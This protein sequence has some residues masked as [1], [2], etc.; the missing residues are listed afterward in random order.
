MYCLT[1]LTL[2]AKTAKQFDAARRQGRLRTYDVPCGRCLAC[3]QHKRQEWVFRLKEE[4]KVSSSAYF[5]TLTYDED[6]LPR[7]DTGVPILRKKDVQ[8]F[9]HRLRKNVEVKKNK[10]NIRYYLVG[11]Y[12]S[13]T[14]RPH[15]HA[16]IFN[17]PMKIDDI[18]C[19]YTRKIIDKEWKLGGVYVVPVNGARI[20]YVTKY[21]LTYNDDK[22]N[23]LP[24]MSAMMSLKPAIGFDYIDKFKAY[25]AEHKE[26]F[27]RS[28]GIKLGMPRYYRSKFYDEQTLRA[29]QYANKQNIVVKS[30]TPNEEMAI[31]QQRQQKYSKLKKSSQ[32]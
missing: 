30:L 26:L 14:R 24:V 10:C 12:G 22:N 16:I 25:M 27:V 13:N 23:E 1:P 3:L 6:H 9:L 5:V 31:I 4:L 32:L 19:M 11:E 15:Y 7:S 29:I 28:Q 17:L 18:R 8:K 20:S 2:V 21:M